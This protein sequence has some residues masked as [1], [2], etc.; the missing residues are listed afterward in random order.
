MCPRHCN[1]PTLAGFGKVYRAMVYFTPVAIK[2]GGATA[3]IVKRAHRTT[4]GLA[5]SIKA[6]RSLRLHFGSDE[7]DAT[8]ARADRAVAEPPP[9][10]SRSRST[11]NKHQG[12]LTSKGLAASACLL[13]TACALRAGARPARPARCASSKHIAVPSSAVK[14]PCWTHSAVLGLCLARHPQEW[15]SS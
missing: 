6:L 3:F 1:S 5:I 14:P 9:P 8:A 7:A 2:V 12:T 10:H 13:T 15:P 4:I 11:S